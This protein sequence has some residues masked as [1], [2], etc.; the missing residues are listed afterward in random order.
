MFNRL[1]MLLGLLVLL[2][3]LALGGAYYLGWL[4]VAVSHPGD[5]QTR[6]SVSVD[7]EK[8]R[9]DTDAVAE[10]TRAAT[11]KVQES[12]PAAKAR[13]L[14]GTLRDVDE[15]QKSFRVTTATNESVTVHTTADTKITL[16]GQEA[17]LTD[18]KPGD[19]LSAEVESK[20]DALTA[21]TVSV[22]RP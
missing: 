5:S 11:K 19:P 4:D 2:L 22:E 10:K 12:L 17:R 14:T 13:T 21:R 18:L 1:L 20:D 15:A 3:G 8:I 7:R 16:N 6:M 9:H